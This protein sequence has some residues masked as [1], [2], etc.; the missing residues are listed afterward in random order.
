VM[1]GEEGRG[2]LEGE[3]RDWRRMKWNDE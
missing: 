3:K 2:G 1:E